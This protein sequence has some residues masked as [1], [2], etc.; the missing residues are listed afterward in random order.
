MARAGVASRRDIERMIAEGRIAL[1]GEV[2]TTPATLLTSL[3]GITVDGIQ[4]EAAEVTRIW[5]F[6]KPTGCLTTAYDPAGRPTVFDL[7][8]EDL[9]RLLSIGRL[10]YNTEGL[11]LFTNDGALKRA[12]ELPSSGIERRYRVRVRGELNVNALSELAEGITIDGLRYGSIIA[13]IEHSRGMTHWLFI[14][15]AEGKNREVRKVMGHLGLDVTRLIRVGYG[16]FE[17]DDL[18]SGEIEELDATIAQRFVTVPAGA[19]R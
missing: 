12:F 11:L 19:R 6:H 1:K 17:L 15:L 13:D 5:R 8:P 18:P 9:P 10:D 2:L 4:V 16:P 14:R 3:A 7:L